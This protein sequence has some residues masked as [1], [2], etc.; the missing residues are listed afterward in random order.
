MVRRW[1]LKQ[2]LHPRKGKLVVNGIGAAATGIATTIIAS[3]EIRHGAWIVI[4]LV[5]LSS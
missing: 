5:P 4:V 1:L 2:W 3:D